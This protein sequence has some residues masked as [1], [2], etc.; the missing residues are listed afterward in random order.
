[1]DLRSQLNHLDQ[2]L[3]SSVTTQFPGLLSD[4]EKTT[5]HAYLVLS[6]AVL[7]EH[8][9][10]LFDAHFQRLLSWLDADLVPAEVV[11]LAFG[12]TDWLPKSVDVSYKNRSVPGVIK[13]N[14]IAKE[15]RRLIGQNHGLGPSNVNGLAKLVGLDWKA[16]ENFH[17]QELADLQ[18]LAT[19]RGE[20]GHLSPFTERSVMLSRQDYPDNVREWVEAGRSAVTKIGVYLKTLIDSQQPQT[21]IADWDGN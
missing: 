17:V 16:F 18:N 5:T 15:F 2:V 3:L 20:A 19:K 21:L 8:L 4:A 6:H 10:E 9:E 11:R 7:E 12:I 1:M 14:P 13:A